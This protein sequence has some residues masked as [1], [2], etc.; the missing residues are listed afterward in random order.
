MCRIDWWS[1]RLLS[2]GVVAYSASQ[3]GAKRVRRHPSLPTLDLVRTCPTVETEFAAQERRWVRLLCA[4]YDPAL[5][6]F[7]PPLGW[8]SVGALLAF[9]HGI[10]DNAPN[11]LWHSG[12]VRRPWIPL[13]PGRA[14]AGRRDHFGH[15]NTTE[16][17]LRRLAALHQYRLSLSPR[18]REASSQGKEIILVLAALAGRRSQTE[19]SI[20]GKTGLNILDVRRLLQMAQQSGLV[21]TRL[22]LSDAGQRELA[23]FRR[24]L[25]P[26]DISVPTNTNPY[27]PKA[28][29]P[30]SKSS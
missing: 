14:T 26:S 3:A 12:S 6:P 30:P 27:Y 10:P 23:N 5:T 18:L 20:A 2:F 17:I 19:E 11:I 15:H 25:R 8:G 22:R 9:S 21:D 4:K 29:R 28:L 13:F 16:T 24:E 1:L 7:T